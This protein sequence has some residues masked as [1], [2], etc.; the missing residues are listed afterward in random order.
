MLKATKS[1]EKPACRG[2]SGCHPT[3]SHTGPLP[4]ATVAG[5]HFHPFAP[6]EKTALKPV[7]PLLRAQLCQPA[8]REPSFMPLPWASFR[9]PA[10]SPRP[11]GL[12]CPRNLGS[13]AAAQPQGPGV[14]RAEPTLLFLEIHPDEWAVPGKAHPGVEKRYPPSDRAAGAE[15]G[16]SCLSSGRA[17]EPEARAAACLGAAAL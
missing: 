2:P 5:A 12:S 13:R 17:G 7:H 8:L 14:S 11:P 9:Q 15:V 1:G 4:V 3:I 16:P 6:A 10:P